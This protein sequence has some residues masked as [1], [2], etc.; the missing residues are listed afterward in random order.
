[1]HGRGGAAAGAEVKAE[2]AAVVALM[3]VVRAELDAPSGVATLMIDRPK[4]AN[5]LSAQVMEELVGAALFLDRR[6]AGSRAL[7]LTGA[8]AKA[9]SAGVDVREMAATGRAD[10]A[11][12]RLAA[13]WAELERK[14]PSTSRAAR[15]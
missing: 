13:A 6:H 1:M 7:V 9:F 5:A 14:P 12:G 3:T 4:A 15:S 2:W 10:A 8:G 11:A